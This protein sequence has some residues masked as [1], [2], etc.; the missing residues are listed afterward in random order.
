[1]LG[2]GLRQTHGVLPGQAAASPAGDPDDAA[3]PHDPLDSLAVDPLAA[4]AQLHGHSRGPV[5][6]AVPAVDGG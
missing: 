6:A 3:F 1:M 2:A 5:G 4:S